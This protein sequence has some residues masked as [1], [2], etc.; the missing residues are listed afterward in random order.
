MKKQTCVILALIASVMVIAGCLVWYAVSWAVPAN[1][2]GLI[3][4]DLVMGGHPD[5]EVLRA[6]TKTVADAYLAQHHADVGQACGG[7]YQITVNYTLSKKV[8]TLGYRSSFYYYCWDIYLPYSLKTDSGEEYIVL[9]QLSDRTNGNKHDLNEFRVLR[10]FLFDGANQVKA[11][12]N[13]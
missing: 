1:D 3:V 13:E 10:A 11:E 6:N 8:R 2:L 4:P 12:F 7:P 5:V 9:V